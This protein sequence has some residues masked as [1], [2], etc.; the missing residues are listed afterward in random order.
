LAQ[1]IGLFHYV[2]RAKRTNSNFH[3][4]I[5]AKDHCKVT[6]GTRA[7]LGGALSIFRTFVRVLAS[8]HNNKINCWLIIRLMAANYCFSNR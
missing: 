3:C 8:K 2:A 1:G 6:S 5:L 4:P 7:P